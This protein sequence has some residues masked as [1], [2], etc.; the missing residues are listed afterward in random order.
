MASLISSLDALA[1]QMLTR[2]P[3]DVME[4]GFILVAHFAELLFGRPHHPVPAHV[5]SLLCHAK[6]VLFALHDWRARHMEM[7]ALVH[8]LAVEVRA[9]T[10][11]AARHTMT[12]GPKIAFTVVGHGVTPNSGRG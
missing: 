12:G 10:S 6:P 5:P 2:V 11:E 7:V 8:L 4:L 9:A 1:P 3:A